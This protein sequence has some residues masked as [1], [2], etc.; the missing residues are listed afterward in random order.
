MSPI[1]PPIKC[2]LPIPCILEALV[3]PLQLIP[4]PPLT[5]ERE[6]TDGQ[7]V[8]IRNETTVAIQAEFRM[9]FLAMFC[10]CLYGFRSTTVMLLAI[11]ERILL[12]V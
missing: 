3:S 8:C 9:V 10:F 1:R 2:G 7:N 11:K 12:N 4:F 6:Q 5:S